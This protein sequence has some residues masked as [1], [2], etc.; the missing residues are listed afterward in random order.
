[1]EQG[2]P[3][4]ALQRMRLPEQFAW[5]PF[6]LPGVTVA[7][8]LTV[9]PTYSV[10]SASL[11]GDT[12]KGNGFV[13]L[14]NFAALFRQPRMEIYLLISF[15]WVVITSTGARVLGVVGACA[16]EVRG[17]SFRGLLRSLLILP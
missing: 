17:I 1:M 4:A 16:I 15:L 6:V 9:Y 14:D 5:M 11:F 3:K 7:V 2:R 8:L 12:A 10:V 13:G